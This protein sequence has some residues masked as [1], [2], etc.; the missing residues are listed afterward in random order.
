MDQKTA[1]ISNER[2]EKYFA[3]TKEAL[4][5]AKSAPCCSKHTECA[6]HAHIVLDMVQRYYDDA[7]HF[8]KKGEIVKEGGKKLIDELEEKGFEKIK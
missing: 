7:L 8:Q 4:A 5:K 6:E 2:L 3:I 1:T